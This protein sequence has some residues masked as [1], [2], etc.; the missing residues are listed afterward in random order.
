MNV[1]DLY[2]IHIMLCDPSSVTNNVLN[3][4][5]KTQ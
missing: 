4:T 1:S 3:G 2:N 5:L